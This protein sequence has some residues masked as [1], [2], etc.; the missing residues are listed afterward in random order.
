MTTY[1]NDDEIQPTPSVGKVLLE[2]IRAHFDD[3][4]AD[5]DHSEHFVHVLQNHLEYF[6]L[7]QVDILDGLAS[8]KQHQRTGKQRVIYTTTT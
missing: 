4:F 3:H 8:G 2:A 7:R 6:S 5:E 1:Y